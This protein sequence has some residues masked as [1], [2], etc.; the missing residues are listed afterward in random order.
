[1]PWGPRAAP[2]AMDCGCVMFGASKL[3]TTWTHKFPKDWVEVWSLQ[4]WDGIHNTM[5]ITFGVSKG[6]TIIL[7]GTKK[8]WSTWYLIQSIPNP[9][10]NIFKCHQRRILRCNFQKLTRWS[11]RIVHQEQAFGVGLMPTVVSIHLPIHL[12]ECKRHLRVSSCNK[13]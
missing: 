11:T 1:M 6:C 4:N 8:S 13:L 2:S 5:T 9:R 10:S 7:P 12:E 3:G